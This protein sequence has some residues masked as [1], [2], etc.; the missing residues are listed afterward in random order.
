MKE[1][2]NTGVSLDFEYDENC[3]ALIG[4]VKGYTVVIKENLSTGSYGCFCWAREGDFSAI[5]DINEYL[6]D[7][8]KLEPELIKRF[9]VTELGAAI[10]L[11]R[12]DD[13]FVNVNTLKKFVY[14]FTTNLSL[15]FYKNCCFECGK[16]ENLA[17]FE[18]DGTAAQ[19]C[20]ECGSKRKFIL[21]FDDSFTAVSAP[22]VV[23]EEVF[24]E[25]EEEI[26]IP[27]PEIKQEIPAE[28]VQKA[29]ND[30]F[31]DLMLDG[32]EEALPVQEESVAEPDTAESDYGHF[33]FGAEGLGVR[34][35]DNV[36]TGLQERIDDLASV[37]AEDRTGAP[38][39]SQQDGTGMLRN[40]TGSG[41]ADGH[42]IHV[43]NAHSYQLLG[44]KAPQLLQLADIPL[45]MGTGDHQCVVV[46][47]TEH[48]VTGHFPC[49]VE[50]VDVVVHV[51]GT[52][53]LV[54]VQT[55]GGGQDD[56][57][58][59]EIQL[60]EGLVA[61]T[62]ELCVH[63]AVGVIQRGVVT[64]GGHV[65]HIHTAL[66]QLPADGRKDGLVA[67]VIGEDDKRD[68][69]V[70]EFF[71]SAAHRKAEL[72]KQ[73]TQGIDGGADQPQQYRKQHTART[74]I[75]VQLHMDNPFWCGMVF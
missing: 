6:T 30:D 23:P 62:D 5:T 14:D 19:A 16:T 63:M 33:L 27:T 10:A 24:E 46:I 3:D 50:D 66:V 22:A 75:N 26:V 39:G 20:A 52:L 31:S 34:T 71:L 58:I 54:Y 29:D 44:G 57:G 11:T 40:G 28:P 43:G 32:T 70:T 21:S 69:P 25:K 60:G 18:V 56:G 8:Q 68:L 38:G 45:L 47:D 41:M 61:G 74:G 55:G 2:L 35:D 48:T 36:V 49:G 72:D 51:F 9:R 64:G 4:Q 7:K 73:H 37:D 15:N 17:V 12:S 53:P 67:L 1:L 65:D 59:E 42:L 13:D